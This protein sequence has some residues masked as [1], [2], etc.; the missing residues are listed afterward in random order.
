[1]ALNSGESSRYSHDMRF[2][3]CLVGVT[4]VLEN[5]F[6]GQGK[7]VRVYYSAGSRLDE[8]RIRGFFMPILLDTAGWK[9]LEAAQ[10]LHVPDGHSLII[11]QQ[12]GFFRS[13]LA[14]RHFS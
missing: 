13:N 10:L 3:R 7:Q 9:I 8:K 2:L 11:F 1:M 14:R 6:D 4:M 12:P 5:V